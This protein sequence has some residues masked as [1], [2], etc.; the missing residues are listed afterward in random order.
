MEAWL[1]PNKS[2]FFLVGFWMLNPTEV[3][4]LVGFCMLIP[5]KIVFFVGF[6]HSFCGVFWLEE[7]PEGFTHSVGP[8]FSN[9]LPF[10]LPAA[11][12]VM[13]ARLM[14]GI[15]HRGYNGPKELHL[16]SGNLT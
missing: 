4:F 13:A 1:K 11:K 7:K 5:T 8:I 16:H 15:S 6:L 2:C 12:K 3:A 14:N 9:I 10:P